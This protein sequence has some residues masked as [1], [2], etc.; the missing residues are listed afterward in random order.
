MKRLLTAV[1][2][3]SVAI[4]AVLLLDSPLVFW[5]AL[6][7]LEGCA[8]EYTA[9]GRR[10]HPDL[11]RAL[12]LLAVPVVALSWLLPAAASPPALPFILIAAAPLAFAVLL[13]RGA[14]PA[15][16]VGGLGW[17]SFGL[18]YLVLPIWSL[19]ELHR[20]HPGI[21][22]VFLVAVWGN[23]SF[24]F[25]VGSR[26]GRRKLAPKLSPKKTWEG[27]LAGLLGSGLIA[28]AGL[29]WI[30]AEPRW[31]LLGVLLVAMVAAQIGDLV[32]SMLKRA[33]QV[34]D[35][36]TMVPGHGGLLDRLDA[37]ILAA[38]VFYG[39]LGVTGLVSGLPG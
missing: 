7:L 13:M 1:L 27:A 10:L 35:S 8:A 26:W 39:L 21:L 19:Y 38:P 18:P 33:A 29:W 3:G 28:A 15:A 6:A 34:K 32:E 24:A 9:L 2:A 36:G 5:V 14:A 17:L 4:A 23:D 22:L 16:A 31:P 20:L 37:I 25:L 12:L 11:P 30:D